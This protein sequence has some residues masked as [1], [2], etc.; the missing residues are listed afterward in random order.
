MKDSMR[1]RAHIAKIDIQGSVVC[2]CISIKEVG[3][4]QFNSV[5]VG[6]VNRRSEKGGK[7]RDWLLR[8]TIILSRGIKEGVLELGWV[9]ESGELHRKLNFRLLTYTNNCPT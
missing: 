4:R 3:N 7:R 1:Q 8:N 5:V 6:P 9:D 2:L